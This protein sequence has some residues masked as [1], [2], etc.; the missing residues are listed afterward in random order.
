MGEFFGSLYCIF[1]DFFGLDLA[2]YLWGLASPESETNS[3]IGI[4]MWMLSIS[5]V[6]TVLF[7]YAVNHPRLNN[8]W[9]W[10]V[11]LGVNALVNFIVGWQMVMYDYNAGKMDDL[12]I[13]WLNILCFG[14]SNMLLSVFF[15]FLFSMMV[16]WRS[17][18]CSR[19][20]F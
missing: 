1:E 14:V 4:G 11:F 9:G 13:D 19:A 17:T 16:K 12:S 10:A 6:V 7:Y 2:N 18:N 8:W 20:P 3:F 15:F 5:L